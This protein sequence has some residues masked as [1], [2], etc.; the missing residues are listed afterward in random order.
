VIIPFR[1]LA[2]SLL[3][4]L[5]IFAIGCAGKTGTVQTQGLSDAKPVAGQ[6]QA[7]APSPPPDAQ[8]DDTHDP[9]ARAMR[10]PVKNMILWSR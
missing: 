9:F 4:S 7:P 10:G 3:G 8:S 2:F 1:L 6:T 5:T